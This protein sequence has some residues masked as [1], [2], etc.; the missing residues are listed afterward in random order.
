MGLAPSFLPLRSW[1]P[2][3]HCEIHPWVSTEDLGPSLGKWLT[4]ILSCQMVSAAIAVSGREQHTA[5][6]KQFSAPCKWYSGTPQNT[7]EK[8]F[9]IF[10]SFLPAHFYSVCFAW[11]LCTDAYQTKP[12]SL[13]C[14]LLL[15]YPCLSEDKKFFLSNF[16]MWVMPLHATTTR[17]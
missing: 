10:F 4:N 5:L 17:W 16:E 13:C 6:P 8:Y 15:Q 3:Y 14:P 12:A 7:W 1:A 9:L 2:G 11:C